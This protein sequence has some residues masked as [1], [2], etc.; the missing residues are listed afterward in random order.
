MKARVMMQRQSGFTLLEVMIGVLVVSVGL[1]MVAGLQVVSKR[2]N[3]DGV[4]RTTASLLA[5]DL[6]ARM[7]ANRPGL[8]QYLTPGGTVLGG[9]NPTEPQA[10]TSATNCNPSQLARR[11]IWE[12]ETTL[13]GLQQRRT[14]GGQPISVGGLTEPSACITGPAAG[15]AG[16]Y[17]VAIAW[18]G[19][20]ATASPDT[21][22]CGDATGRYG[23]NNEYRR[24]LVLPVFIS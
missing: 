3:Y 20:L 14:E 12:F 23:N 15:G 1:L 8:A 11:D 13:D 7:R 2:S 5:H 9:Q 18:R 24:V 21:S 4:Q 16:M 17:Q 19:T 6:A 10:C 22:T